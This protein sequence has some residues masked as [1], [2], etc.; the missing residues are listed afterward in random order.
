MRAFLIAAMHSGAGK[1]AVSCALM[2]ALKRQGLRVQAFKCGPDYIDPMFHSGA[3]GIPSRNL[4]LFLQGERGVRASFAAASADVAVVEG[5]MG[6]YDGLGGTAEAGAWDVAN[7]L[8]LP[9]VLV[10]R[11]KGAGLTLAAQVR[12]LMEFRENSRIAALILN[13]C[14]E[15]YARMLGPLLEREC[16]VPVLG[17]LPTM[18]E[19]RIESR[20]L[21]LMTAGEIRDLGARLERLAE[22]ALEHIDLA[23]LLRLAS[24]KE[25]APPRGAPGGSLCRIAVSKDEAFCF[26]YEDSLDAL[27]RAG[28]EI[29]FF[30]PLRDRAL[31]EGCRGLLLCG[32]YPE[33]HARAL[34]ENAAMRGAVRRALEAGVPT[35]AECG[36]FLYLQDELEG[37]D[38]KFYPMCGALPG[39]GVRT[40]HLVRFGYLR[41]HAETDSLLFRRGEEIPAHEF[42]CW[43][44]TRCGEE[45]AA[46]KANGKSWRCGVVNNRLYAAFPHLHFGGELPLAERFVKACLDYGTVT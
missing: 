29:V 42:H 40:G 12:G 11:P 28:A 32:G 19:A 10:L 15:G 17:Y 44:S 20:H 41:L 35:V 24:E 34:A 45:L 3:L 30:S 16:G 26:L 39:R 21:G 22:A 23:L 4:D 1:T 18:A 2:A 6:Y 8:E 27:R 37:A 14:T 38:G 5:A 46:K 31:P 25:T 9:A 43:D 7:R 13:D 36:G 33:L